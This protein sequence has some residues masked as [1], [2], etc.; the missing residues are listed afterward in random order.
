[1]SFKSF[2][3]PV[4]KSIKTYFWTNVHNK[5]SVIKT[6][7]SNPLK[8]CLCDMLDS[9]I[10]ILFSTLS[11]FC[12]KKSGITKSHK[13]E[14]GAECIWLLFITAS[15]FWK[16]LGWVID[17]IYETL[18]IAR[19]FVWGFSSHSWIFH[20]Y[21]DV[22]IADEGLQILTKARPLSSEG[23]FVCHTCDTG[24]PFILFILEDPWHSHLLPSV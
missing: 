12:K 1:M 2:F 23:S 11:G 6:N 19:L 13:Q 17:C 24:H 5:K 15:L 10:F 21:K 22:T 3:S 14:D 9:F 18:K 7:Y 8:L 16:S 20:S 4:C